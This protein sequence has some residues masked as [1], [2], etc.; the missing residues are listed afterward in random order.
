VAP[1]GGEWMQTLPALLHFALARH[2]REDA[3]GLGTM[4][5]LGEAVQEWCPKQWEAKQWEAP[6][7]E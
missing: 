7:L 4:F 3:G 6:V 5:L 1:S 2:I